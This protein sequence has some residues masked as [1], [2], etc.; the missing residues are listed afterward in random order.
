VTL[1]TDDFIEAVG[2]LPKEYFDLT[3]FREPHVGFSVQ[4][5]YPPNVRFAPAVLRTGEPDTVVL[6]HVVLE[7]DRIDSASS[8]IPILVRA[9]KF[10]QYL[11]NHFDYD[12]SNNDS[13]T[14]ESLKASRNSPQPIDIV[15]TEEFWQTLRIR[16]ST[17]RKSEKLPEK[18]YS[19]LRSMSMFE[20]WTVSIRYAGRPR[21]RHY[22]AASL[23]GPQLSVIS[24]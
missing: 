9:S 7:I 1:V 6:L 12:F 21:A 3:K 18:R 2:T 10:S 23:S 4:R 14:E 8:R 24:C 5:R 17:K 22:L 15:L 16:H 13:P 11:S 19:P 20:R